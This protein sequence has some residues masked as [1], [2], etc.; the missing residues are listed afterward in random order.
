MKDGAL[1]PAIAGLAVGIAFV[2]LLAIATSQSLGWSLQFPD[3]GYY[4]P[5]IQLKITGLNDTYQVGE[6]INFAVTQRAAGCVF[7]DTVIVKNLETNSVVWRFNSTQA[8]AALLGCI[9]MEGNPAE[10]RMRMNTEDSPPI[11]AH[12]AGPYVVIAEHLHK[13]VQQE[14][15]VV[16]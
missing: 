9:S 16:D 15:R 5:L 4:A 13:K 8:N 10:S 12:Q 14:F 3:P 7:P 6:T 11:I 1:A 2:V